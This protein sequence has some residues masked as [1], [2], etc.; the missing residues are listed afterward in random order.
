MSAQRAHLDVDDRPARWQE[1]NKRPMWTAR[2]QRR[3]RSDAE[4]EHRVLRAHNERVMSAS[5]LVRSPCPIAR[6]VKRPMWTTRAH[7][8]GGGPT[9]KK[10]IEYLERTTSASRL[11]RSPCTMARAAEQ[12]SYVDGESTAAAAVRRQRR[13]S[14]TISAQRAHLDLYDHSAQWRE[15]YKRPIWTVRAHRHHRR[16]DAKEGH[17]ERKYERISTGG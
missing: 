3:R 10:G 17:H 7:G 14:S 4:E 6:A 5:R 12:T 16:P 13:A 11:V 9:P 8:G 2:A 15:R 1:R